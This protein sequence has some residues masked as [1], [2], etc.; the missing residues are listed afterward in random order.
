MDDDDCIPQRG[1]WGED[2]E[3]SRRDEVSQVQARRKCQGPEQPTTLPHYDH[4]NGEVGAAATQSAVLPYVAPNEV[5]EGM[6]APTPSSHVMRNRRMK[7]LDQLLA[8]GEFFSRECL[9]QLLS[10]LSVVVFILR[11]Q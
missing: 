1:H 7:K 2:I 11:W 6:A 8:E 3:D 4:R 5:V 9:L 10:S